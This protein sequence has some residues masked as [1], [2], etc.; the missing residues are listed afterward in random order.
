MYGRRGIKKEQGHI[1]DFVWAVQGKPK[2]ELGSLKS[3]NLGCLAVV[4]VQCVFCRVVHIIGKALIGVLRPPHSPP[5]PLLSTKQD[6]NFTRKFWFSHCKYL[7]E[8]LMTLNVCLFVSRVRLMECLL[9]DGCVRI[10]SVP[11]SHD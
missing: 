2:N 10:C 9:P 11:H 3:G 8:N 4:T 1:R 7:S 5:P 6:L